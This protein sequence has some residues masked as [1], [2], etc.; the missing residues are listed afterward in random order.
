MSVRSGAIACTTSPQLMDN[1]NAEDVDV[2]LA[3]ASA[4]VYIGSTPNLT[5]ANGLKIMAGAAAPFAP[6]N[7]GT[8]TGSLYVLGAAG[9]EAVSWIATK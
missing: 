9:S 1:F 7:I 6:I 8:I 5:A 4:T 3:T 2:V